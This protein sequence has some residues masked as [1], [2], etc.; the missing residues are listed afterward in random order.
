MPISQRPPVRQVPCCR[1]YNR[2]THSPMEATFSCRL[3]RVPEHRYLR[4]REE[5]RRKGGLRVSPSTSHLAAP[6]CLSSLQHLIHMQHLCW[7]CANYISALCLKLSYSATICRQ[8]CSV[9]VAVQPSSYRPFHPLFSLWLKIV[10][11]LLRIPSLVVGPAHAPLVSECS[12]G[13]LRIRLS[14][15]SVGRLIHPIPSQPMGPSPSVRGVQ[16][17]STRVLCD[18]LRG[19]SSAHRNATKVR[20]TVSTLFGMLSSNKP[21]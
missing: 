7:F 2:S 8:L 21:L 9:H 19:L 18:L 4:R 10:F 1:G 20:H 15:P 17:R 12:L 13:V 5:R 14:I 6:S 3:T 11:H 16:S